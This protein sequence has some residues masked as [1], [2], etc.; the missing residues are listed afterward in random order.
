MAGKF[1]IVVFW[2]VTQ[3]IQVGGFQLFVSTLKMKAG[4]SSDMFI[5]NY[6]TMQCHMRLPLIQS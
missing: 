6:Q 4:C 2:G 1:H 3:C 5:L